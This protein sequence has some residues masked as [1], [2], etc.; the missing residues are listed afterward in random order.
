MLGGSIGIRSEVGQGTEVTIRLPLMRV[1]G[2][3]SAASTPSVAGSTE[4]PRDDAVTALQAEYPSKT[5]A[6]YAIANGTKIG[7]ILEKYITEWF[8]L[9]LISAGSASLFADIIL[10][11]E[12]EFPSLLETLETNFIAAAVIVLCG[13]SSRYCRKASHMNSNIAVEFVSKPY[14]P[15]KLA[16][17]LKLCLDKPSNI[18]SMLRPT[19][20]IPE[21]PLISDAGTIVPSLEALNL[22]PENAYAQPFVP[23]N[24]TVAAGESVNARMAGNTLSTTP[25]TERP[26]KAGEEFPFPAQGSETQDINAHN[27]NG[28]G[29]DNLTK[30]YTRRPKLIHRA[31]EPPRPTKPF[32]IPFSAFP[33]LVTNT[34]GLT[35]ET[36]DPTHSGI[37]TPRAAFEPQEKRP[38]RLLLV[39][40]NTINLRLLQT[41]MRKRKYK[42]VDSA[43]NGQLAVEAAEHHP[44]GYDII[45]MGE[46]LHSRASLQ[47]FYFFINL[48]ITDRL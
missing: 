47:F 10:V 26:A 12:K 2:T 7:K 44:E 48:V 19:V 34:E 42:L 37:T 25:E 1:S 30:S 45:F 22:E 40:D 16:K 43:V 17:A 6:L 5:I 18:D 46:L 4:E 27:V 39:D 24:G 15:Y 38:P 29:R 35:V 20:I 31:T 9:E 41:Y 3:D 8:G 11:D 13:N 23:M 33:L 21:S 28:P 14:G 36:L 32:S